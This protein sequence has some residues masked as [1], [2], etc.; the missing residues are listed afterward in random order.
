MSSILGTDSLQIKN[1]SWGRPGNEAK[2]ATLTSPQSTVQS[3][4]QSTSPESRVQSNAVSRGRRLVSWTI[5]QLEGEERTFEALFKAKKYDC[6]EVCD[7]LNSLSALVDNVCWSRQ[8]KFD[9]YPC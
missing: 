8:G 1:W 9:A 5:V 3:I 6:I 2:H 7:D 4:V